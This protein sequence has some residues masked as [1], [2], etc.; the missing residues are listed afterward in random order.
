MREC[1]FFVVDIEDCGTN[2]VEICD[3][4]RIERQIIESIELLPWDARGRDL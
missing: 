4:G 2:D 3:F 1:N